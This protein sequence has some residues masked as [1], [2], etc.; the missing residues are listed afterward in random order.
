[1]HSYMARL[2]KVKCLIFLFLEKCGSN[3]LHYCFEKYL[4]E[5]KKMSE[6]LLDVM[7]SSKV[8][9]GLDHHMISHH[10]FRSLFHMEQAPSHYLNHCWCNFNLVW[11][12]DLRTFSMGREIFLC[13]YFSKAYWHS[14]ISLDMCP[15]NERCRYI[16]RTSLIGWAHT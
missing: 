15:A 1:M 2:I 10:W 4:I 6:F 8:I 12:N 11:L 9:I 16:V 5:W 3:S 14:R 13:I 7:V